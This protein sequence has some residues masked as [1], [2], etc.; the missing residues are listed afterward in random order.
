[1]ADQV[2]RRLLNLLLGLSR[3]TIALY[4]VM[5]GTPAG[6]T[7]IAAQAGA[8]SAAYANL[9]AAG[10]GANVD[11]WLL[12]LQYDTVNAATELFDL[13]IYNLT[14]T[15]TIYEDKPDTTAVTSNIAP[16]T[17][18]FPIYC[19]PLSNIQVRIGAAAATTLNVSVLTAT[20]L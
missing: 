2:T 20:G 18:P 16:T 8:W 3:P 15:T 17:L 11:F 9:I 19:A 13:Q 7:P 1:M 14:I 4:P 12:Q 10:L 6:G 5:D